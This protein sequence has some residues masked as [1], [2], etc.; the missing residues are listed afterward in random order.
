[1]ISPAP[2]STAIAAAVVTFDAPERLA[3]CLQQ[4]AMQTLRPSVVF[5]VNNGSPS[6]A[7]RVVADAH[8]EFPELAV[9][10]LQSPVNSGPAGGHYMGMQ[11]ALEAGFDRLWVMDDDITPEMNCLAALAARCPVGSAPV[12]AWPEQTNPAGEVQNYR[13]EIEP[14]KR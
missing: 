3:A 9:E 7:R 14:A 11:H 2:E 6:I 4:M 8:Q 12:I 1:M 13:G 10:L 5:V